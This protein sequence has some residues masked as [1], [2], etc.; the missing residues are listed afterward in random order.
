MDKY[1]LLDF[2]SVVLNSRSDMEGADNVKSS[3]QKHKTT[4][5][6]DGIAHVVEVSGRVVTGR[7]GNVALKNQVGP[8]DRAGLGQNVGK[9]S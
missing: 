1:L 6:R 7:S 8:G 5:D 3:H 2:I 4:H 9:H